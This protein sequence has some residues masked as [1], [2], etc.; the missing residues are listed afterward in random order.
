MALPLGD[1]VYSV[2][3]VILLSVMEA[4]SWEISADKYN[5]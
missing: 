3:G 1:F 5:A 4:M 2:S